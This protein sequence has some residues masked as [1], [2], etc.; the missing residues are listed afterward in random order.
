MLFRSSAGLVFGQTG[1]PWQV[2][3]SARDLFGHPFVQEHY[4]LWLP[5]IRQALDMV[6]KDTV[7]SDWEYRR[8][9]QD[10]KKALALQPFRLIMHDPQLTPQ[11]KQQVFMEQLQAIES[12]KPLLQDFFENLDELS[13]N[14]IEIWSMLPDDLKLVFFEN[15]KTRVLDFAQGVDALELFTRVEL[16]VLCWFSL[17]ELYLLMGDTIK[18]GRILDNANREEM[19]FG[20][21]DSLKGLQKYLEGDRKGAIKLFELALQQYKKQTRKRKDYFPFAAGSFYVLAMM[22]EDIDKYRTRIKAFLTNGQAEQSYGR[23]HYRLLDLIFKS[24]DEEREEFSYADRAPS[25]NWLRGSIL[26]IITYTVLMCWGSNSAK[27][28][29]L[30]LWSKTKAKLQAQGFEGILHHLTDLAEQKKEAILARPRPV[31][32]DWQRALT[33]LEQLVHP[34]AG[35]SALRQSNEARVAWLVTCEDYYSTVQ[36]KLQKRTRQGGWTKGRNIALKKLVKGAFSEAELS[37]QDMK[38]ISCIKVSYDY[39]GWGNETSYEVDAQK[40]DR[41]SVV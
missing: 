17:A 25:E 3:K 4:H 36:P 33:R 6:V 22:Q 16:P 1:Y 2:E 14:P 11:K 31:G 21:V 15:Q 23:Q 9:T 27:L 37:V 12:C 32:E 28:K 41:K 8:H 39:N 19:R 13:D 18:A 29:I 30:P 20:R 35:A 7:R 26:D 24:Q 34:T 38:I 10:M 40:A 5:E